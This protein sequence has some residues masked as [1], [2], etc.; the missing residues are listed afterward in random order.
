MPQA[1]HFDYQGRWTQ[2]HTATPVNL[3]GFLGDEQEANGPFARIIELGT[4]AGGLALMLAEIYPDI[5]IH[6]FDLQAPSVP[7]TAS[8]ITQHVEDVEAGPSNVVVPLITGSGRVL[9]L[10]DGGSKIAELNGYAGYLKNNDIIMAHDC[11]E[12][13]AW[14]ATPDWGWNEIRGS[15][16]NTGLSGGRLLSRIA[17][18]AL[19]TIAWM[20]YR[21]LS[22]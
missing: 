16:V 18:S 12:T 19:H 17:S 14:A 7:L 21:V 22:V 11:I 13:V 4:G 2:Q 6:T 20:A 1:G 3:R 10:C 9:V 5:E 15:D 8:N